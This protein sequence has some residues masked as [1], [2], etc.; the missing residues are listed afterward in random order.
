[1]FKTRGRKILGDVWSR[2]GRTLLVSLAIFIGVTGTIALFSLSDIIVSQLREDLKEDELAMMFVFISST[3]GVELDDEAYLERLS[4]VTG[5]TEVSGFAQAIGYFKSSQDQENFEQLTLNGFTDPYEPELPIQPIRLTSG[6]YP[7]EGANEVA[8]ERRTAER[9]NL[10]VG[11]EIYFRILSPS[12]DPEQ[13][14]AIGT[15]ETWT[16]TGTIFDP[17]AGTNTQVYSHISDVNY[18]AG[19]TG[20]TGY[21]VRFLDFPTAEAQSEAFSTVVANETP[22]NIEFALTQDPAQ[23]QQ[24]QGA[25]TIAGTMSFL[26]IVALIVSGFLVINV[27]SSIVVEQ[28]RQIGV[29]KSIGASRWDNFVIY[30]G[31]AFMYGL[32]GVIPGVIVGIPGGNAAAHALAPQV[33]TVLEGFHIS[34]PSIIMGILV[35]LLIPVLAALLPVFFGTRV[36]ILD[37]MTDLGIDAN[38]GRGPLARIISIL[39]IPITIRQGL[40]NVSLKKSRLAFTVITLSIAAGAFMGIFAVFSSLTSGIDV[41]LDTFN[42]EIGVFPNQGRDPE[43]IIGVLSDNFRTE[44]NNL[45]NSIEPGFQLQVEFEGY[46]APPTTGGPPGILAY[47]YDI[48]SPSPAFTFTVDQGSAL[49]EENAANGIILSSTL[50]S[51]MGKS[52]GDRIVMRVPGNTIEL[53]VV[54]ISE[55]PLSQVWIDWR[56]LA[57]VTGRTI[58]SG[59]T[60]PLPVP[61]EASAFIRYATTVEAE[62]VSLTALGLSSESIAIFSNLLAEGVIF[63]QNEPQV[64][65]SQ[66]LADAQG[67]RVGDR[68]PL[69]STQ[70]GGASNDYEITGILELPARMAGGPIPPEFIGAAWQTLATLDGQTLDTRPLP[71]GYFVTTTLTDATPADIDRVID[72]INEV[73]LDNGIPFQ[74]F[75]FVQLVE[76]ISTAFLTIQVIL[77]MVAGLIALVGALGLLTTLSMSVFERQKEIGVMRSIGASSGTVAVQFLTEGMVVGLISWV[78]GLPLAYLIE[79]GLLE[80]T[81]F[82]ETFPATFP[83]SAAII[84]LVGMIIITTIASLWPSLAAA[85]K[86]V[87]DILRYQ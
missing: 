45:I 4:R 78:V 77:Q 15:V 59:I 17:Y 26:A 1:M 25:Q 22:Y 41:F 38:Y 27:I 76:D 82:S 80:V 58:V 35:G 47:G 10:S 74:A 16:I 52:V 14:G 37:A 43:E 8:I 23:N 50:A 55:F 24:I 19:F 48:S 39:P 36:T 60:S 6:T 12:R 64:I 2:K 83:L 18:V 51:N 87:S 49:N 54:G 30:C 79:V 69:A 67:Y 63:S 31:I 86:T 81:G 85:R 9:F 5:V 68:L 75:N 29:M 7:Q 28:K 61:E 42:V 34:V 33:G 46:E 13:S 72:Q 40:S 44:E 3:S 53:Y 20:L 70:P 21:L 73:M 71:Q 32:I 56:T 84:G 65:I 62:G 66:A 11:D 57:L